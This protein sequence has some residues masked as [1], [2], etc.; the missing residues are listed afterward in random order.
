MSSGFNMYHSIQLA[1]IIQAIFQVALAIGLSLLLKPWETGHLS[2]YIGW[3]ASLA[4]L[5]AAV[6]LFNKNPD[7]NT[8]STKSIPRKRG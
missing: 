5:V 7:R 2:M 8:E 6:L 3:M 4:I 1:T